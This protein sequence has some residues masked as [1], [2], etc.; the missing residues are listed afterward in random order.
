MAATKPA[1][2]EAVELDATAGVATAGATL[3]EYAVACSHAVDAALLRW[4]IV[5]T[6]TD[7]DGGAEVRV[8]RCRCRGGD[9]GRL[10][11]MWSMVL[12]DP[13]GNLMA[14]VRS[15]CASYSSPFP[16]RGQ[17]WDEG[18]QPIGGVH[19]SCTRARLPA[20]LSLSLSLSLSVCVCV[21]VCL[22]VCVFSAL[23]RV[24]VCNRR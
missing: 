17:R 4:P 12:D 20:S 10:S 5:A 22:C 16:G 18:W 19:G 21:C 7:A 15:M 13:S 24:L 1:I 9:A 6:T 3:L 14:A 2:S 23:S 8:G 11:V